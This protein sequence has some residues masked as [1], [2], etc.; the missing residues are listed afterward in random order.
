MGGFYM[1]KLPKHFRTSKKVAET[2]KQ[3]SGEGNLR[4]MMHTTP[5]GLALFLCIRSQKEVYL[6]L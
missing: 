5:W 4:I 2:N 6:Q 1:I 3:A